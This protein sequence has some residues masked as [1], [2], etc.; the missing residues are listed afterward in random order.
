M[1]GVLFSRTAEAQA[2]DYVANK[3]RNQGEDPPIIIHSNDDDDPPPPQNHENHEG[4]QIEPPAK[5][6]RFSVVLES[7]NDWTITEEMCDYVKEN[8]SQFIPEKSIKET[9]LNESPV[10]ENIPEVRSLDLFLKELME[11]QGKRHSLALDKD[12]TELNQKVMNILGP[13]SSLWFNFEQEKEAILESQD[14]TPEMKGRVHDTCRLFEQTVT[15][16]GQATN[17]IVYQRR[18]NV[19]S[20]LYSD[21]RKAKEV[22]KEKKSILNNEEEILFGEKFREFILE[23]VKSKK[24]TKEIVNAFQTKSGRGGGR[25]KGPPIKQQWSW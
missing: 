14:T 1:W 9:I 8:I 10:P 15:M 18:L 5:K 11:E 12:L 6:Q 3:G 25:F 13:F 7:S 22:I 21:S 4:D 19:L 16:I 24:K 20:A 2:G 23:H 17:S